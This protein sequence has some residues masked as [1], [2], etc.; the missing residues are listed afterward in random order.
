MRQDD[1]QWRPASAA[2]AV[3]PNA[4]GWRTVTVSQPLGA[5]DEVRT[6]A[7]GQARVLHFDG[8]MTELEPDS[9]LAVERPDRSPTAHC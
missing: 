9:H 2:A 4:P 6:V 3:P 7:G 8:T 1:V 5:G